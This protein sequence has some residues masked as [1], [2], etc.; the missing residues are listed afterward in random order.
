M[1]QSLTQLSDSAFHMLRCVVC[2]A[3][4]DNVVKQQEREFVKTLVSHLRQQALITSAQIAQLNQDLDFPQ[5]IDQLLPRVT[6]R[7]DRENLVLFAG[8]L[9]MSDGELHPGEDAVLKKIR[10]HCETGLVPVPPPEK[11]AIVPSGARQEILDSFAREVR[12]IVRQ[13]LYQQKLS[14]SGIAPGMGPAAVVDAFAEKSAIVPNDWARE[15][16]VKVPKLSHAM[17]RSLVPGE[18]LVA[19]GNFHWIYIF[20]T[21]AITVALLWAS[22]H[23]QVFTIKALGEIL[24]TFASGPVYDLLEKAADNQKLLLALAWA[25][26]IGALLFALW[27]VLKWVTTEILITDKRMMIKEGI[28]IIKWYKLN[29]S[30]IGKTT[31][32]QSIIGKLLNYGDVE[33]VT[34]Y[35]SGEAGGV[36]SLPPL[37]DP[38]GL[39]TMIDRAERMWFMGQGGNVTNV[40]GF[41]GG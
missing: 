10:A 32:H 39:I 30:E 40:R 34:N 26:G 25:V 2:V 33:G 20:N 7:E 15:V 16:L 19:K 12:D 3:H 9:A 24:R 35:R 41:R 28:L 18:R 23:M 14:T 11:Q 27:R 1:R 36:L 22:L 37:A 17:R 29:F 4:A 31:V 5:V 21:F 6:E 13:E 38:H 8:L